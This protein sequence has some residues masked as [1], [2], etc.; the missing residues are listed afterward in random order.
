MKSNNEINIDIREIGHPEY[1][2]RKLSILYVNDKLDLPALS[3]LLEE[4]RTGGRYGF[5][6]GK[7]REKIQGNY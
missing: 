5:K 7:T 1:N 6:A 2:N 4:S 3:F